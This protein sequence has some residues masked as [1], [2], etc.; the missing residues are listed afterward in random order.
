M[1]KNRLL[2]KE[3]EEKAKQ[4]VLD[5]T[6]GKLSFEKGES[7]D[8]FD[9]KNSVGL[10]VSSVFLPFDVKFESLLYQSE[11]YF[12]QMENAETDVVRKTAL[13]N[14]QK[15]CYSL[16]KEVGTGVRKGYIF[17]DFY[18]L[19]CKRI[20]VPH[21]ILTPACF[22]CRTEEIINVVSKKCGKLN[23]KYRV[24]DEN[25][26]FIWTS[27]SYHDTRNEERLFYD[28]LDIM[29]S[30]PIKFDKIYLGLLNKQV[31]L[32][33][34]FKNG[35]ISSGHVPMFLDTGVVYCDFQV[36]DTTTDKSTLMRSDAP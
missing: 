17:F 12:R 7:P 18:S 21:F 20:F 4:I 1:D 30:Y 22:Q 23:S 36:A 19:L 28:L 34:D 11:K 15:A 13:K 2:I 33:F 8:W 6:N 26:L 3:E 14:Y 29:Y 35:F 24:F 25:W 32:I 16:G 5:A 31:L 27:M 9:S 10:E